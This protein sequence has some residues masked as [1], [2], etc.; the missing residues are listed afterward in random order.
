MCSTATAPPL[1]GGATPRGT[2]MSD[3]KLGFGTKYCQCR[4]CERYFTSDR[5][6][7]MLRIGLACHDPAQL[8]SKS[9]APR[10][11][12]NHRGYWKRPGKPTGVRLQGTIS[13][14]PLP[15]EGSDVTG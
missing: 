13:G 8:K 3:S 11:E 12:L 6:F 14:D 7:Q 1:R 10:L 15:R 9:G 2:F 4:A 5:A